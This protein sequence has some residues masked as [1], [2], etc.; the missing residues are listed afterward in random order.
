MPARVTRSSALS[1]SQ[2]AN[3]KKGQ[4]AE[5]YVF[6]P[7][8]NDPYPLARPL[9]DSTRANRP[10]TKTRVKVPKLEPDIPLNLGDGKISLV[11]LGMPTRETFG[12]L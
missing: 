12:Q 10:N 2:E 4:I 1:Q 3:E 8:K 6:A 5:S 11:D 7:S 9:R